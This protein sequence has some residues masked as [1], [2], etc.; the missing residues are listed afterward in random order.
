MIQTC[1][2]DCLIIFINGINKSVKNSKVHHYA[3][4]TNSVPVK[5]TLLFL[6]LSKN[7]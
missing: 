5:L 7:K 2:F 6:D 4:D 3:D 1:S